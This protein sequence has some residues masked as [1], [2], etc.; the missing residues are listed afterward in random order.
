MSEV[1]EGTLLGGK[2]SYRQ[3]VDGHRTGFEPVL[4]AAAV[5]AKPG[6]SVLE[7]GTGAGAAL[8]CLGHRVQGLRA[9]GLEIMPALAGLANQNFK[10]NN[11]KNIFCVISDAASPPFVGIF[12]HVLA[13]PPW[14]DAASTPSPDAGRALAHQAPSGLLEVWIAGLASC[15]KPKGVIYLI[16]PAGS[17]SLAMAVLRRQRF[18]AIILLPLWPRAGLAAKQFI[19]SAVRMREMPDQIS[20]GL[21]LHN[22]DGITPQ[23]NA[24]L[25]DGAALTLAADRGK[26][27][28]TARSHP[29]HGPSYPAGD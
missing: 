2:I 9:I 25:R 27:R 18:G 5:A 20:P 8:L 29:A 10:N 16:L 11:F 7:A 12:D 21:I 23:A 24:I 22:A 13:N 4:L 3:F 26:P 15:L 6:E 1:T 19:V 14:F 17:L 28:K